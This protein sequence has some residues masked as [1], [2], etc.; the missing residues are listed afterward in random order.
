MPRERTVFATVGTTQFDALV[1]KLVSTEVT[2][3]LAQ[4]GYTRL[5]IQFGRGAEPELPTTPAIPV[6]YYRF[7][8]SLAADMHSAAL[9]VSHAGA[10]SIMEGLRCD[11]HLL[12]VVNDALMDN[13]Q[14][15]R[16]AARIAI[17]S[18]C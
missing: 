18:L 9:I 2:H 15:A 17:A 12:V 7:K 10:G 3:L 13:H 6:E 5:V 14:Q 11:A 1:D 8:D 4:Q 16:D